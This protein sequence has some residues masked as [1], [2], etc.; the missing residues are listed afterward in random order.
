M[1]LAFADIDAQR[2]FGGKLIV[3]LIWF[4]AV[5][6]MAARAAVHGP[7]LGLGVAALVVAGGATLALPLAGRRTLGRSLIGVALMGQVSLLVAAMAGSPWQIDMHM[8]YFAALAVLVVYCDWVVILVGA[9]TVAIHHLGLAYLLPSAV[10][11]GGGNLGRVVVHAVILVTEAVALIGAI[12]S[13]DTMFRVA[14]EA[15][16]DK[17]DTVAKTIKDAVEAAAAAR[18]LEDAGRAEQAELAKLAERQR[19]EAVAAM[20]AELSRL[21]AGDLTARIEA[22]FSNAYAEIK[23][24]FN[25]AVEVL[26]AAMAAISIAA[27]G[28]QGGSDEIAR[29][30]DDLS[31]RTEKQ[32]ASLEQ[33]AASLDQ[34]TATVQLGADGARQASLVVSSAK[35]DAEQAGQVVREAVTAMGEIE[36]SS[37][38]ITQI[39]GVIDEIAF[40][41]NLLALNAGVEAARA[42]ESG[43]GF[44]I[45]AQE[46]RA[47]AQRSADAAR[48]I[49]GLI[50]TSTAQ[51]GR[52]VDLVGHTGAALAGIAKKVVEV[53]EIISAIA[54]SSREQASGLGQVNVAV[55]QMGD[56]TQQNAAMVE[57]TTAAATNLRAEAAE[58][59]RRVSQFKLSDAAPVTV[60]TRVAQRRMAGRG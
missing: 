38:K 30:S 45:V 20:A 27:D 54:L 49:K 33:T 16:R 32:A 60:G 42:G 34:I 40:Q 46:V 14:D 13:I 44:A 48:Q 4:M 12:F 57:Q 11:P 17:A 50:E 53:D 26:Q 1:T 7:I 3:G 10:F 29:A 22:E 52:G 36:Q 21:A 59:A 19:A 41:T 5:V 28:V 24:D 39:I 47:L 6:V 2:R 35:S 37:G 55:N 51:V 56:V 9:I 15:R 23:S 18:E 58:L 43:R 31:R 8:G 25:G